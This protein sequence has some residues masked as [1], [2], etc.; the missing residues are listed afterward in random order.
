MALLLAVC[1]AVL[2]P[3]LFEVV[4]GPLSFGT[5]LLAGVIIAVAAGIVV[6][7]FYRSSARNEP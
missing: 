3:Y 5:R 6:Y 2:L 4:V 1:A 7:L